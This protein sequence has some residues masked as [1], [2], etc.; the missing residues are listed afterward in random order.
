VSVST[1]HHDF[2]HAHLRLRSLA[3]TSLKNL[4]ARAASGFR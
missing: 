2:S 4:M 1:V 3:E